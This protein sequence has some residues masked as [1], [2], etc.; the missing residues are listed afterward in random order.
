MA[1]EEDVE[2]EEEEQ[3]EWVHEI[4]NRGVDLDGDKL[5]NLNEWYEETIS[6]SGGKPTGFIRDLILRSFYGPFN[7]KNYPVLVRWDY[8]GP[9]GR[10]CATDY[11]TAYENM[12]REMKEGTHFMENDG[13]G[14]IWLVAGQNPGGLYLY[15]TKAPPYGERPLA[16]IKEDNVDEFFGKVNWHW[17][18][19]RLHKWNLWGGKVTKF[20]YPI[21]GKKDYR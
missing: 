17:L 16:L 13:Q 19:V 10:P 7:D 6:G 18:F 21:K 20:P 3:F 5:D 14:W 11:D 2:A 9:N 4:P 12:K 15:L 1:V 8:T